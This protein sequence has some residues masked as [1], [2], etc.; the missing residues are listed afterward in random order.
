MN[1]INI[2]FSF[3]EKHSIVLSAKEIDFAIKRRLIDFKDLEKIVDA[4][5]TQE[6]DNEYL[7]TIALNI[8]MNDHDLNYFF[9]DLETNI[10]SANRDDG[11]VVTDDNSLNNR[12]RYIILLWLFNNRHNDSNDYGSINTV[13][14][15]FGYPLDMTGFVNYMPAQKN[16]KTQGYDNILANWKYYLYIYEYLIRS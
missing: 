11:T 3:L 9:K 7:L 10:S 5:L 4:A 8:L 15:D 6:P 16:V 12:L 14:A 13:Y 1:D 2:S